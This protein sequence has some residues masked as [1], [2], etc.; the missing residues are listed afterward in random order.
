MAPALLLLALATAAGA[1]DEIEMMQRTEVVKSHTRDA[2]AC[3]NWR[4]VYA[5]HATECGEARELAF[6]GGMRA[7]PFLGGEFCT[8]WFEKLD[9]SVCVQDWATEGRFEQW[10]YVSAECQDLRGGERLGT[11]ADSREVSWKKCDP[12]QDEV[13]GAKS[14]PEV[15]A[16]AQQHKNDPGL[17]LKMAY[18]ILPRTKYPAVKEMLVDVSP[19]TILAA[20]IK[21]RKDPLAFLHWAMTQPHPHIVDSEDGHPPFAVINGT[22]VYES[23]FSRFFYEHHDDINPQNMWK[24]NEYTCVFGCKEDA[25]EGA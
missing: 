4:S 17:V 1:T 20:E 13:L 3:L 7:K 23:H 10:C 14:P 19:E 12:E 21:S 5:D 25:A 15:L 22:Q 8:N 24:I 9:A 2:C 18:P 11:M 16:F 6:A